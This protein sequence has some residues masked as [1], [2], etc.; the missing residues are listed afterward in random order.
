MT[1]DPIRLCTIYRIKNISRSLRQARKQQLLKGTE[2]ISK[3]VHEAKNRIIIMPG[4][5]V[6]ERNIN[7]IKK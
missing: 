5:G 1:D 3:L 4:S 2:L 6:N 7:K